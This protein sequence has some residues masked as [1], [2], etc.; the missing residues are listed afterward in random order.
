MSSLN[1]IKRRN[2]ITL[3]ITKLLHGFGTGM[4]G[5]IY[6][7]FLLDLTNSFVLTGLFISLGSMMQFTPMPWI[8]KL[9]DKFNRKYI[10]ITSIPIYI[11]GLLFLIIASSTRI[12]F[13][14]FGILFYFLGF[15]V[16]NLNTQFLVAENTGKSKGLIFGFM[17]FSFFGGTIAGTLFIILGFDSRFYMIIFIFLLLIEEVFF[18]FSLSGKIHH[19]NNPKNQSKKTFNKKENMWKK[20]LKTKTLRSILIFFT[21]DIF[22]YSISLSI[23]SG[24]LYNYY[25]LSEPDIALIAL[26]FNIGNAIFQIPAGRLTDKIGN[27]KT[28]ILSQ[29]FGFGFFFMNILAVIFWMNFL[30]HILILTLS[31]GYLLFALSVCTFIPAEQVILTNLGEDQK[32]ESYG[33]ISFFRGIGLLPTGIL[34][35]L[36]VENVHYIAPFIFSAIGLG[37]DL[38]FLL[39]FFHE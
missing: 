28:L 36:I 21:L 2:L 35:A 30:K 22:V 38:I 37:I 19:I 29:I 12:Y 15:I 33:I 7:P 9:S 5:I 4:F 16:N 3:A 31:V 32:A 24:G 20:I 14:L 27:K 17:Y 23:Y 10:L 25:H 26:W 13:I 11:I 6:Q 1:S 39:K 8:G 18:I 34:G